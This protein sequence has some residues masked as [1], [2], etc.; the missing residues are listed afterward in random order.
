MTRDVLLPDPCTTQTTAPL[1]SQGAPRPWSAAALGL[2]LEPRRDREHQVA[3]L[4]VHER[5]ATTPGLPRDSHTT[6]T[7]S[8]TRLAAQDSP[9]SLRPAPAHRLATSP[10]NAACWTLPV[11][12]A[13]K[14]TAIPHT[15]PRFGWDLLPP[16]LPRW[17]A[18]RR[19]RCTAWGRV[20]E[21]EEEP[22][23]QKL[24][25]GNTAAPRGSP[26]LPSIPITPTDTHRGCR[27]TS[28]SGTDT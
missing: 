27:H 6:A 28:K 19:M 10:L 12:S 23:P 17:K 3:W 13:M 8:S 11:S 9:S 26:T 25:L 18:G 22:E 4:R 21:P 2:L 5:A 15:I 16:A 14:I 24:D 20:S 1:V 7:P